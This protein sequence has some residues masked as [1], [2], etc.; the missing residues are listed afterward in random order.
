MISNCSRAGRLVSRG[1]AC[2]LTA[3]LVTV[4]FAGLGADNADAQGY[5]RLKQKR[6][7]VKVPSRSR[8]TEIKAEKDKK[9]PPPQ[10]H[11]IIVS[12]P[13]QRITVHGAGGFKVQSAVSSGMSGFPTPTG[14]FSVIQ[15][16]RYHRSN[17]YSGAPMPFMQRITWSGVAMH[18][19]VL[20][21]YPASHG[22]IRLT[23]TFASELWT[24]T[25]MGVRVVVAPE[26]VQAVELSHPALPM[27]TLT[28]APT[29]LAE[30]E[31]PKAMLVTT[32]SESTP[33]ASKLLGPL[34]R[35]KAARALIVAEAP[36]K[37]RAAKEAKEAYAGKAAEAG[38]ATAA[39]RGAEQALAAARKGHE[40]AV[41]A[42]ASARS[43]EASEKA[44]AAES[45][46]EAK[47]AEAQKAATEAAAVE[48]A[49]SQ[50]A[51][52]AAKVASE[53]E[54]Q[55]EAATAVVRAGDRT[56]EPISVFISR[57]TNRV[58]IRQAWAPIHEAPVTFKEPDLALGTHVYVAMEP[59]DDG[60]AMRWL[61]VSL[62]PPLPGETRQRGRRG[63]RAESPRTQQP[64]RPHESAA[65]VLERIEVPEETRRLIADKLWAGAS[66]I[67]SDQGISHETGKYTDFIVLSR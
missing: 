64:A 15:K 63:D 53:A 33:A 41:K 52:A 36:A 57:K 9:V 24:M 65:S 51:A 11:L 43:P 26:D 17:I 31:R 21:G 67:V 55:S 16:N 18:A 54:K 29:P 37:A 27:P 42:V 1:L 40:A 49:K 2:L 12:I 38:K 66:L 62:A 22:C 61:S 6:V 34:D 44:K 19:G 46:A 3:G 5:R 14:V 10:A 32:S 60:K 56:A 28:P 35:A 4:A 45:A 20:P 13:K 39:L 25:K 50:D 8:S 23:H 7:A 59:I 48:A 47:L 30:N 58:Y